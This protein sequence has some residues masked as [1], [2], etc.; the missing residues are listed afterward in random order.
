M[1]LPPEELRFLA[2]ARR[3]EAYWTRTGRSAW[4]KLTAILGKVDGRVVEWGCGA[5][6]VSAY[7]NEVPGVDFIGFDIHQGAIE[8]CAEHLTFGRFGTCQMHPPI[9]E[10][11][12]GSCQVIYGLSVITHLLPDTQRTWS[13]EL[14]RMLAP[15]GRL[16]LTYHGPAYLPLFR[17]F[18]GFV[19]VGAGYGVTGP[20]TE[21]SNSFGSWHIGPE[22]VLALF[23]EFELVKSFVNVGL[24]GMEGQQDAVLLRKAPRPPSG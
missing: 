7:W 24:A 18:T 11:E 10:I 20:G 16:L 14:A 8:W 21:G 23:P 17:T 22:A 12:D 2:T 9:P 6:R 1:N 19:E 3:D 15:N 4:E 5:G 13:Y